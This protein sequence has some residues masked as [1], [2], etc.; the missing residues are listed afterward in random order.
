M[1]FN[2][3]DLGLDLRWVL[4][5]NTKAGTTKVKINKLNFITIKNIYVSKD[6]MNKVKNKPT[7]WKKIFIN[8]I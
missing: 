8:H 1:V 4:R 6:T 2:H 5:Y 3:Y 7:E